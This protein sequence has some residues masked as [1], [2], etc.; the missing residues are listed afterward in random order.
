MIKQLLAGAALALVAQSSMAFLVIG[1]SITATPSSW[2]QVM[3]ENYGSWLRLDAQSFRSLA[4][5]E[6]PGDTMGVDFHQPLAIVALGFNDGSLAAIGKSS[7][8]VYMKK[9]QATVGALK[10]AP[11]LPF[12]K[13]L[14]VVPPHTPRSTEGHTEV[15]NHALLY[16]ALMEAWGQD[17]VTCVDWN[18]IGYYYNTA[19]GIHPTKGFSRQMAAHMYT[20]INN[21]A[22]RA[23][24]EQL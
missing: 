13:V 1:D 5:Y 3:R 11:L 23:L 21:F 22:P 12:Q 16:C 18:D 19:D 7:G 2:P 9:L 20:T 6:L 24:E 14:V 15:R 10:N 17:W 4:S 8:P